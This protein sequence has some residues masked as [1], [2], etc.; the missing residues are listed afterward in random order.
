MISQNYIT[1]RDHR[2]QSAQAVVNSIEEIQQHIFKRCD[3]ET[4]YPSYCLEHCGDCES[5]RR[6]SLMESILGYLSIARY[7]AEDHLN[8]QYKLQREA[9]SD[10]K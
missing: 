8:H 1:W 9:T 5:C 4:E 6:A 3:F 2:I 10:N 7:E